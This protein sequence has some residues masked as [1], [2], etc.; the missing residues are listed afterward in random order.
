MFA[1]HLLFLHPKNER[2]Q[3]PQNSNLVV[4]ALSLH[5]MFR[6]SLS[7]PI[8]TAGNLKGFKS[9]G[10]ET[11]DENISDLTNIFSRYKGVKDLSL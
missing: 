3:K 6:F 2:R 4:D 8:V 7:H 1:F 5:H 9:H 11:S 10:K